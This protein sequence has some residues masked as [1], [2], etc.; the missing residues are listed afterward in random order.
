MIII[1]G[2]ASVNM[3][4]CGFTCHP[5]VECLY[6]PAA[7]HRPTL[8]SNRLYYLVPDGHVYVDTVD[9]NLRRVALW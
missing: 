8:A 1:S 4:S 9:W 3:V 5:H 7:E 2:V 6:F